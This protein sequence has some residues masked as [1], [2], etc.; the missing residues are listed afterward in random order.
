MERLSEQPKGVKVVEED[1]DARRKTNR[2]DCG[3]TLGG[4]DREDLDNGKV[5]AQLEEL[6]L[7]DELPGSSKTAGVS[8]DKLINGHSIPHDTDGAALDVALSSK[9]GDFSVNEQTSVISGDD[10]TE[11]SGNLRGTGNGEKT[12]RREDVQVSTFEQKVS[13]LNKQSS[14]RL[15]IRFSYGILGQILIYELM[16]LPQM[17]TGF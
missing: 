17:K 5:K 1:V 8:V 9:K 11:E 2:V 12:V 3:N 15:F 13:L 16:L 14:L 6:K 4:N 10:L 7:N